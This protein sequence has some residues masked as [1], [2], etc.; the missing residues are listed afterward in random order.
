MV[1]TKFL[2]VHAASEHDYE[3]NRTA[4]ERALE[5]ERLGAKAQHHHKRVVLS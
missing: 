2:L 1:S 3:Y 5:S 4:D